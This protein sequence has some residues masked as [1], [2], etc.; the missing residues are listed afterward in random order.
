MYPCNQQ[1]LSTDSRT[2]YSGEAGISI[3]GGRPRVAWLAGSDLQGAKAVTFL[4]Y[5]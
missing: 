2:Y 3:A 1:Q 5:S 4:Y